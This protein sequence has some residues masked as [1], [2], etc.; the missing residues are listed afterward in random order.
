MLE[1][2]AKKNAGLT[3]EQK[4]RAK[5]LAELEKKDF[6]KRNLVRKAF[7]NAFNRLSETNID[8]V[9]KQIVIITETNENYSD[10]FKPFLNILCYF[11]HFKVRLL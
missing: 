3:E 10:F 2:E 11:Y 7:V 9:F 8:I 1:K 4:E 6:E 5:V